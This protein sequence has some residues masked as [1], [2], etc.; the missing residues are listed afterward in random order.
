MPVSHMHASIRAPQWLSCGGH[1]PVSLLRLLLRELPLQAAL[2]LRASGPV[3]A[4]RRVWQAGPAPAGAEGWMTRYGMVRRPGRC[5]CRK[6]LQGW[7][8]SCS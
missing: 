6:G 4:L 3:R 7:K 5:H 8:A 1:A 2:H